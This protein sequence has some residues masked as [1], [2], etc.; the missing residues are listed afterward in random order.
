M[1]WPVEKFAEIARWPLETH[2]IP[3]VV[4]LGARDAE[5][6]NIVRHEMRE[7]AVT[8]D[9][10]NLRE[11]I[12]L[13]AGA[14]LFVGNDSGPAHV[15]A[16]AGRPSVVIFGATN[17]VQWRPWQTQHR[18]V[19]TGAVFH[20]PKGDKSI[21]VGRPRLIDAISLEEV[22]EA[23]E[24]LLAGRTMEANPDEPNRSAKSV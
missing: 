5:I 17:P 10:L 23:C 18:V 2:G 12:A 14:R 15:A 13:V 6:A 19:E 8:P 9:P 22:R 1:R 24:E 7:C 11:L 16:A 21:A 4:N 3:S 20:S